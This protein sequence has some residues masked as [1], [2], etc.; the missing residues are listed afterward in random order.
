MRKNAT[1]SITPHFANLGRNRSWNWKILPAE[2]K[3]E[4]ALMQVL[5]LCITPIDCKNYQ[6]GKRENE[7]LL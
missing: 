6:M 2:G 7:V 4:S 1:T 5:H 3:S